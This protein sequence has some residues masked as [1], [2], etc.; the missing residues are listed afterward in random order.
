MN[1][2][3]DYPMMN[4]PFLYS[5]E[6][7]DRFF[8]A[9]LN[10]IKFHIFQNISKCLIHGLRTFKH[11]KIC[12]LCD[13]I[14]EKYKKYRIVMKEYSVLHEEVIDVFNDFFIYSHNRKTFIS[15]CSCQ[16]YWFNGM[17]ED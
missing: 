16:D 1:C 11:N 15:P 10:K 7:L 2:C 3:S 4:A 14:P 17:W 9:S 8:P 12:E 6:R 13:I 5:S